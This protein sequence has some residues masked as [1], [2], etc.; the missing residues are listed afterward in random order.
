M[1]RSGPVT[2]SGRGARQPAARGKGGSS[3]PGAEAGTPGSPFQAEFPGFSGSLPELAA[4]LRSGALTPA[5]VPLLAITRQVL[6][7]VRELAGPTPGGWAQTAPELLPALAGVI[8]LKARLLLPAPPPTP[9]EEAEDWEEG[10]DVLEGVEALAELSTLVQFLSQRRRER[11]GLIAARPLSLGL[12]RRAPRRPA[13]SLVQLVEAARSAVR[14]VELP[15]LAEDRLTLAGALA[16]LRAFGSRLGRFSFW[17]VHAPSWGERSTYFAALL[18]GVKEGSCEAVQA[19]PYGEIEVRALPALSSIPPQ[20]S[21]P[22]SG[23]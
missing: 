21:A 20:P 4:A 8:A 15:L 14:Q 22:G 6:D 7:G 3:S 16:T 23:P 9:G 5:E 10:E 19:E 18:E 13:A 11:E 17:S 12:P 2:R 1:T